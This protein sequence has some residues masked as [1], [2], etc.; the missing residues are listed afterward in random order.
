M[1]CHDI[2]REII[3]FVRLEDLY[4]F[5]KASPI[6]YKEIAEAGI[7]LFKSPVYGLVNISLL[8]YKIVKLRS[9]RNDLV[10]YVPLNDIDDPIFDTDLTY[11]NEPYYRSLCSGTKLYD[12]NSFWTHECIRT[13]KIGASCS[14]CDGFRGHISNEMLQVILRK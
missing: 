10:F 13:Q 9:G 6:I 12:F 8:D 5:G 3:K 2:L 4:D 14:D 7:K 1:I 11:C